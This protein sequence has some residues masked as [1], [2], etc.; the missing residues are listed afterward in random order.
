MEGSCPDTASDSAK[1]RAHKRRLVTRRRPQP[2]N[3]CRCSGREPDGPGPQY[4][5]ADAGRNLRIAE[6]VAMPD[7]VDYLS[8][9]AAG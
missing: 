2:S 4:A 9:A 8:V 6:L 1:R 5:A 7:Q 3:A